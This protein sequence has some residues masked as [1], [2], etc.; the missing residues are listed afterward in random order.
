M[1]KKLF[2]T[3]S[4]INV[5]FSVA[6]SKDGYWDNVR[7]TNET[8][9]LKAGEKKVVKTT[10]FPE[11]TTEVVYRIT[12]LNDNQKLSS[13]LVSVLKAIP[14]PTGISQGAAGA[15]FLASTISGDDK[16]KYAIFT[17]PKISEAFISS[18][19]TT[20]ACLVQSTPVN[21]EARILKMKSSDCITL[22]TQNLYFAIQS[23]NWVL[24]EK[25]ILEVVPWVDIKASRG[26]NSDSKNEIITLSKSLKVYSLLTNKDAFSVAFL[27]KISDKYTYKEFNNLIPIE[28]SASIELVTE[29]A[30]KKTG[31][32]KKYFALF[33]ERANAAVNQG[34]FEDAITIIQSEL[35]NKNHAESIDYATLANYYLLSKQFD[36]SEKVL[37]EAIAKDTTDINLQLQV[38]HLY[39]FT[40]RL[41]EAKDIH[42]KYKEQHINPK[43]S[44]IQQTNKDFALFSKCNLP[45]GNFKKILRIL[46]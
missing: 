13:S 5:A 17:D 28:R 43:T 1:L 37:N 22:K 10:D 26:W 38:A 11:G 18:G 25:V 41:S 16:C 23:D 12:M 46:E 20:N 8:I 32:D 2:F 30:L 45:D 6:Q 33:R 39:L 7:T 27:E 4:L 3:L 35:I 24:G 29:E 40:D 21:K 9:S 34:K 36:K 44:W 42:K 14:D 19:K 15:V 31:E